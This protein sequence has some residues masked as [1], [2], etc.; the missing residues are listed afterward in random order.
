MIKLLLT[1]TL[2]LLCFTS[3]TFS[4]FLPPQEVFSFP[5]YSLLPEFTD[6][7]NDGDQDMIVCGNSALLWYENRSGQFG[8]GIPINDYQMDK[9][10][11]IKDFKLADIDDDGDQDI[12]IS[13]SDVPQVITFKNIGR[14]KF[15]IWQQFEQ[16]SIQIEGISVKDIDQD[17]YPEIIVRSEFNNGTYQLKYLTGSTDGFTD[18]VDLFEGR[19]VDLGIFA[20]LDSDPK[21]EV[22]YFGSN[23][24]ELGTL[25]FGLDKP[26]TSQ[27]PIDTF[28]AKRFFNL[29]VQ[30]FNNDGI[31]EVVIP[32]LQYGLIHLYRSNGNEEITHYKIPQSDSSGITFI[33]SEDID[34]DGNLD[35]VFQA[36]KVPDLGIYW[37]R[38]NGT[39]QLF[40]PT[41]IP[42]NLSPSQDKRFN[43]YD[44]QKIDINGD[45]F[46]ELIITDK[47]DR[48]QIIIYPGTT[49]PLVF[50][51]GI[52]FTYNFVSMS[53]IYPVDLDDDADLDLV[54]SQALYP[55]IGV[56]NNLFSLDTFA[57]AQPLGIGK[58]S[59]NN[60][61]RS[62]MGDLN[63]DQI[64]EIVYHNSDKMLIYKK[65]DKTYQIIDSIQSEATFGHRLAIKDIDRDGDNDVILYANNENL[66]Y[67]LNLD[68]DGN[69]SDAVATTWNFQQFI[70]IEDVN[71]DS[72]L[73]LIVHQTSTG[74]S[75]DLL[76]GTADP[77]NFLSP[78][79][80]VDFSNNDIQLTAIFDD[81]DGDNS[82]DLV[83]Q[84]DLNG[85]LSDITWLKNLNG[86]GV[87]EAAQ[88]LTDSNLKPNDLSLH[89]LN[90]D[91]I[92]EI[93]VQTGTNINVFYSQS[94]N[95]QY[96]DPQFIADNS[97]SVFNGYLFSDLDNDGD[98]DL[99]YPSISSLYWVENVH[100]SN[101]PFIHVYAYRDLN[102]NGT[103]ESF[104]PGIN[105]VKFD[106]SRSNNSHFTDTT[107]H[108]TLYNIL[109]DDQV[110]VVM[111]T[112]WELKTNNSP[113]TVTGAEEDGDTIRFGFA[114]DGEIT[115]KPQIGIYYV[116]GR[117]RCG[118]NSPFSFVL[119]NR[120]CQETTY[121]IEVTFDERIQNYSLVPDASV[122]NNTI[123]WAALEIEPGDIN[124]YALNAEVPLPNFVGDS[125]NFTVRVYRHLFG[126][127]LLQD[128]AFFS[129]VIRCSY[130]PNDKL[131]QPN[132]TQY[133]ENYTLFDET[134]QYT[135]R[136]QNTGND[137][138]YLVVID[139]YLS[140]DLDWS[141]F[142]PIA[143]SHPFT[144]QL[145]DSGLV[146]FT[147]ADIFLPDSTTNES[148]S[149]G[150]V[151]FRIDPIDSLSENTLIKNK[152]EI[153]F[154]FNP[155]IIT[156]ET[157]SVLV[158]QLPVSV[159]VTEIRLYNSVIVYPNPFSD[160]VY[161]ELQDNWKNKHA[162]IKIMDATGRV[163]E[164]IDRQIDPAFT[165][166]ADV[167]ASGLYF[168]QL[169]DTKSDEI[170]EQGKVIRVNR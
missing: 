21:L 169:I 35:I 31:D 95:V 164:I 155:A 30:D 135:V 142:R 19:L 85:F 16:L 80:L 170:L 159:D 97:N 134:I 114:P 109:P 92:K 62:V 39:S 84:T 15:D 165:W 70:A 94:G 38:N 1:T 46:E 107:G 71:Q 140:P 82:S 158:S 74:N 151:T 123:S 42:L 36:G 28:T 51:K 91:S 9:S 17:G 67:Y 137:T 136:F 69:F 8:R 49:D 146:R 68:G 121:S 139:D 90:N 157:E 11:Y 44:I 13:K 98:M 14:G 128:S 122:N 126:N 118:L 141:T 58:D 34:G 43:I 22:I 24:L 87:F 2:F 29:L 10:Q 63:G 144:T 3:I 72:Y 73:D 99:F 125:L 117:M 83:Y 88:S 27:V 112:C 154:D 60:G 100:I 25:G 168:W 113:Y 102:F 110:S 4:Q 57:L 75:I 161:F 50:E 52:P 76:L 6:L 7:D 131:V 61:G 101:Y 105:N 96:S 156:N 45:S 89:D 103:H 111:D 124:T 23:N 153:F 120:G 93:I 116:N 138:A 78:S 143:A 148:A 132:R 79:R 48:H 104:E 32:D 145:F 162:Q 160:I 115:F 147:F 152:A 33:G 163:I 53:A 12:I 5:G 37:L 47:F 127:K 55:H 133:E 18:E 108:F 167:H 149:N 130:D 81:L 86:T 64:D 119:E 20:Q 56:V 41:R 106:Y 150:F 26:I 40:D 65:I 54:T 129:S 77:F 66:E 166:K 59:E